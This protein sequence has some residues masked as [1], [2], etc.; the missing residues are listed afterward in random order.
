MSF[1]DLIRV[2]DIGEPP[3]SFYR[4]RE[5][6]WAFDRAAKITDR[7]GIIRQGYMD[8]M[9]ELMEVSKQDRTQWINPYFVNFAS[10]FSPIED[11]AWCAI[12]AHRAPLYPQFPVFNYFID[13]ANPYLRIG[14]ELDG[15]DFHDEAKDRARD[16]FL[17]EH[18]WRIFR[19]KGSEC[20]AKYRSPEDLN[21]ADITP[22]NEEYIPVVSEWMMHTCEGLIEAI[23]IFYFGEQRGLGLLGPA[24]R[25]LDSHRLA[26]FP[27]EIE[28]LDV[29]DD[30]NDDDLDQ[31]EDSEVW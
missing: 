26:A 28:G 5:L 9:P 17:A 29:G 25:A 15:R 12:R 20:V 3:P 30:D 22:S 4:A 16:E 2:S 27:L 6:R 18:D 8:R 23:A 19:I 31:D 7:W 1:P 10:G 24:Y 11:A 13:F 14:V 21:D